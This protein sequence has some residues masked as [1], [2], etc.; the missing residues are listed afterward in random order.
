MLGDKVHYKHLKNYPL[1]L[2][3]CLCLTPSTKT[4]KSK[5]H[6]THLTYVT[7]RLLATKPEKAPKR[8][9]AVI[10]ADKQNPVFGLCCLQASRGD[11]LSTVR[12]S[13]AP[14][15]AGRAALRARVTELVSQIT[16]IESIV[17]CQ[18]MI[19]YLL[20]RKSSLTK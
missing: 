20:G 3:L 18:H 6:L 19:L 5:L 14:P 10:D 7:K 4:K 9:E 12:P 13:A 8:G 1:L 16:E 15:E 11:Q 2:S 17:R